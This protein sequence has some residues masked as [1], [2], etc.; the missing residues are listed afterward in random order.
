[1]TG[2]NLHKPPLNR[3]R[4]RR[5]ADLD[6]IDEPTST[7]SIQRLRKRDNGGCDGEEASERELEMYRDNKN[8]KHGFYFVLCS[9][10]ATFAS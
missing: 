4:R 3:H 10:F 7:T 8:K 5:F 9:A 2:K 6:D 1:M